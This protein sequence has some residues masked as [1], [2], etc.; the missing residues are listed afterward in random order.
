MLTYYIKLIVDKRE[1]N[2]IAAKQLTLTKN[3]FKK[4]RFN[5]IDIEK[6][7]PNYKVRV[8]EKRVTLSILKK[9]KEFKYLFVEVVDSNTLLKH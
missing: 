1:I 2:V 4:Q 6:E 8:L 5:L 3:V 9:Y 7:L